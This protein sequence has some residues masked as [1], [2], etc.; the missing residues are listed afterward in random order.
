M[1]HLLRSICYRRL[2]NLPSDDARNSSSRKNSKPHESIKSLKKAIKKAWDEMPD[3]L[4]K[5]VVDNWSGP[6]QACIDAEGGYIE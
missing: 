2:N 4:V 1:V 3:D 6:L 5:R